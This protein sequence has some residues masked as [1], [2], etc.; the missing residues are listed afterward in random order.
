[1]SSDVAHL[2]REH[3]MDIK[4]GDGR[5]RS[6]WSQVEVC[7]SFGMQLAVNRGGRWNTGR[8]NNQ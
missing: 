3:A 4:A 6:R 2:L 7:N 8:K 5:E 1:M